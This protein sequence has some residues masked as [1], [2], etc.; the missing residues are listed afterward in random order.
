MALTKQEIWE[1][2]A[3]LVEAEGLSLFDLVPSPGGHGAMQVFIASTPG[4]QALGLNGS[5]HAG[6]NKQ[7]QGSNG[8]TEKGGV[9]IE[10]CARVS[11]RILDL[12]NIEE[13]LPGTA[14]LQVSSPGINRKLSRPEHFSGAVGEHLK[15]TLL[16]QSGSK[17]SVRGLLQKFDGTSLWLHLDKGEMP[18]TE[19]LCVALSQVDTARVDYVF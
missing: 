3:P 12:D 19:E 11:R 8:T 18:S 9:G 16:E 17:R 13:I 14:E 1:V 2:I 15:V 5:R 6:A 10:D 4:S 7:T